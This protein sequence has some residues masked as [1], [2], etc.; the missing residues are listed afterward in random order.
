MSFNPIAAIRKATAWYNSHISLS[1]PTFR[2]QS[3]TVPMVV[4]LTDDAANR[5]LAAVGGV[6]SLSGR[7]SV[8]LKCVL[9]ETSHYLSAAIRGRNGH[10]R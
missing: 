5:S 6:D 9:L 1:F 4:L 8:Q 3:V 2:S 7:H 10:A